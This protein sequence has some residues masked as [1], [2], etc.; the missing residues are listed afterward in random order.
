MN[1]GQFLI[2]TDDAH[3]I[4]AGLYIDNNKLLHLKQNNNPQEV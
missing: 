1:V 4:C 3:T 2:T